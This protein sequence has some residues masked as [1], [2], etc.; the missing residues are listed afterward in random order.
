[1]KDDKQTGNEL[2]TREVRKGRHPGD[3]YVR[4]THNPDFQRLSPDFL[5]VTPRA[6]E[7]KTALSRARRRIRR[8]L[9]GTPIETER[10]SHERLSK[11]KA[12][13]VFGSDNVSSSA[14][15]TEEMMRILLLA[16]LGALTFTLPL[17]IAIVVV[18]VIV[19]ISYQQ[20]IRAYPKG[21]SAYLVASGELGRLPGLTAAASLLNDYV[22]TVSVS[23]AAGVAALSSMSPFFFEN[24]VIVGVLL[25]MLIALGNLR[26]IRESG[27][28][29]AAP[30]YIYSVSVFGLL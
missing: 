22:L 12:L 21:A 30:T 25:I 28:I 4:V 14:Y 24:R 15:A 10:E 11:L 27:S 13:A 2:D 19:V 29:F 18:L 16:G 6:A 26:G 7:P 8:L 9:I 5:S 3:R 23:I 17:T 1:V 20:T